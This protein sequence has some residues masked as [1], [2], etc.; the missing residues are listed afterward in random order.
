MNKKFLMLTVISLFICSSCQI[1]EEK[2]VKHPVEYIIDQQGAISESMLHLLQVTH[3]VHDGSLESIVKATQASWI[4]KAGIER[5]D[6]L[7]RQSDQKN[8]Y[9]ELFEKLNVVQEIKPIK[10]YYNYAF[11]MGAT[12]APLQKRLEYLIKLWNQGVRFDTLV[13][14]SGARPLTAHEQKAV[15]AKYNCDTNNMPQTEFDLMMLVYNSI[16]MPKQM[17]SVP[18]VAVN[19]PMKYSTQGNTIRP[20]TE[21]TIIHWLQLY[22]IPGSCLLISNQPYIA[23]QESV[24]KNFLP[25]T[26]MVEAVGDKSKEIKID[27]YLDTFA[28][29]LYQEQKRLTA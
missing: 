9:F 2:V 15:Q 17:R 22:P 21:D 23:Y 10:K 27:V 1:P 4:R 16:D 6:I 3:I 18:V 29:I 11:W 19:A 12:Y 5:W 14:L 25:V 24:A 20:S 8:I 7:D 13:V 26:F 28:R